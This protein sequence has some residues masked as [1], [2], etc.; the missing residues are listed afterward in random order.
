MPGVHQLNSLRLGVFA[1]RG[2]FLKQRLRESFRI[3]WPKNVPHR[4]R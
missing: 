1:M 4:N 2:L 3:E